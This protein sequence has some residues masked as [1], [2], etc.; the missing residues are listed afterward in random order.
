MKPEFWRQAWA[1]GRTG[2]HQQRINHWLQSHWAQVKAPEGAPVFV[3][4]SGRSMDMLWLREQGHEIV[5]VELSENACRGFFA[6][7]GLVPDEAKEG[8]FLVLSAQG[9]TLYVGNLFALPETLDLGAVYDRASI[10]ALPHAIRSAY[11]RKLARVLPPGAPGLM[12]TLEYPQQ[13]RN[14]PPFS[15]PEAWL[16]TWMSPWFG[17]QLL[18]IRDRLGEGDPMRDFGTSRLVEKGFVVRRR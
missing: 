9:F 1:E 11:V 2:F 14:G 12:V 10:I 8:D 18:G 13:E 4:L 6:D 3:P 15:V 7:L 5:G 17:R 16:D